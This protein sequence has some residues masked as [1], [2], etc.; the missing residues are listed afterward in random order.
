MLL[1]HDLV[2]DHTCCS[3][4]TH[5]SLLTTHDS[6]LTIFT[7]FTTHYSLQVLLR[8]DFLQTVQLN[9]P[10]LEYLHTYSTERHSTSLLHEAP[11]QA[12]DHC[13]L[14]TSAAAAAR[15]PTPP[16]SR[17]NSDSSPPRLRRNSDSRARL[18]PWS[19]G[20]APES[21]SDAAAAASPST[22][23]DATLLPSSRSQPD[24]SFRGVNPQSQQAARNGR[25]HLA[26]NLLRLSRLSLR[27][28]FSRR[29]SAEEPAPRESRS[30]HRGSA[31]VAGRGSFVE[32]ECGDRPA[33]APAR[34]GGTG[35]VGA[36]GGASRTLH[37]GSAPR[38]RRNSTTN[39]PLFSI[40]T[41]IQHTCMH[42]S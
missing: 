41:H 27:A 14:S 19:E 39:D 36:G 8:H 6:R 17:R 22:T 37:L 13:L 2:T 33:E 23:D 26:A 12:G 16:M 30:S 21:R 34:G 28:G 15:P 4:T 40:D 20:V 18:A 35:A 9:A 38:P 11:R 1:R 10:I 3:Q 7:I 5:Y 29:V 42:H 25:G 32:A 24:A 31:R